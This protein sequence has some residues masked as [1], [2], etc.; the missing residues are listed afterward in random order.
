MKLYTIDACEKLIAH[1]TDLGGEVR[2]IQEG[3]LGLGTVVCTAEG[4]KAAIITERYVNE[5]SSGHA[6]R[7]FNK[8]P[9]KYATA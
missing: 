6:I 3:T 5:W 1:Y 2:T 4:K 8:L 9:K 7:L